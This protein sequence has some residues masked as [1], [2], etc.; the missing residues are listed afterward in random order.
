MSTEQESRLEDQLRSLLRRERAPAGFAQCVASRIGAATTAP[1]LITSTRRR[2]RL[3]SAMASARL[4]WAAAAAAC[5]LLALGVV[6]YREYRLARVQGEIARQQAI[7]AL[8][9]ASAKLNVA[10][11]QVGEIEERGRGGNRSK[12]TRRMERL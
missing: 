11:K 7:L 10:L 5:L 12:R 9:I 6:R 2:G 8:R 3:Y 1:S 4:R